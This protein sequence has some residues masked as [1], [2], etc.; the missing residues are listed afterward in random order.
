MKLSIVDLRTDRHWRSATGLDQKRFEKLLSL[1]PDAYEQIYGQSIE[2]RQAECPE[3]P[4]LSTYEDLLL[5]TLFSLKSALS[6]DLLG[7]TTGMDGS[8]AKRNQNIG[9]LVIKTALSQSGHIP[10]THF[11]NAESFKAYFKDKG[12]V[13]IDAT[14][15]RTQR[16]EDPTYQEQLYSGKKKHTR[17][18]P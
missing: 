4:T 18:K 7:F 1:L 16:P 9:L 10:K 13:L 6:F 2:Q 12:L 17:L 14:E 11:D 3:Q 5:F 15:Q 8:T